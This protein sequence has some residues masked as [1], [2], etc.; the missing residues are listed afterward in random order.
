MKKYSIIIC[1]LLVLAGCSDWLSE[2]GAPKIDYSLYETEAGI[3][4]ALVSAYNYLR[5]GA[6]GE[7]ASAYV[8]LGTDLFTEGSD[9][10]WRDSFDQYGAKMGADNSLLYKLWENNYKGIG[11][12]NLALDEV[13][14]SPVITEE[15]RV[16]SIGSYVLYVHSCIL[17]WCN[18]LG[19]FH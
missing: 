4:A 16:Q 18:S 2:D 19:E 1:T 15:K 12:C 8:E 14:T 17:I 7:H 5:L 10:S 6:S 9:G 13:A 11:N 3:D